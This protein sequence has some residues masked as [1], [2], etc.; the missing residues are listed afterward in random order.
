MSSLVT[1]GIAG[2]D[3]E[4]QE[5]STHSRAHV[6][7]KRRQEIERQ[8]ERG[9]ERQRQ[10]RNIKNGA[11]ERRRDRGAKGEERKILNPRVNNSNSR[12]QPAADNNRL[13]E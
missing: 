6:L 12:Q 5:C 1:E 8:A 2:P 10:R 11:K 13:Q 7:P 3:D 4:L 9:R